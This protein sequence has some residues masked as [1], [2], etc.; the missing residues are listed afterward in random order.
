MS[1]VNCDNTPKTDVLTKAELYLKFIS[2]QGNE[3][4]S[5]KY[6]EKKNV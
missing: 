1:I 4:C 6:L 2:Q 3:C 5:Q